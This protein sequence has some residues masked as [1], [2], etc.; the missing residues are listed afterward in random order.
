MNL[1]RVLAAALCWL[2]AAQACA[3]AD[4]RT[5]E[6]RRWSQ[7]DGAPQTAVALAQT[8][9]GLL[10]F[11]T[12]AGMYT[13]DGVRFERTGAVYR[14]QLRSDNIACMQAL[15]GGL[16]VGYVFGGMSLFSKTGVTHYLPGREL[17]GGSITALATDSRGTV[18]A[19]TSTGVMRL[20]EGRWE[21]VGAGSAPAESPMYVSVDSDDTVW[22]V[23]NYSYQSDYSYYAMPRGS[24]HF[25]RVFGAPMAGTTKIGGR[26]VVMLPGDRYVELAAGAP[27][28]RLALHKPRLYDDLLLGGPA[29]TLWT[30]REDGFVRLARRADGVLEPAETFD[31]PAGMAR[32]TT[33]SLLDREGNLWVATLDGVER[34]RRHRLSRLSGSGSGVNWLAM[35]GLGDEVWYGP[36][37]GPLMRLAADGSSRPTGL[38]SANA[39]LR[40]APDH[41][42][43]ATSDALWEWHGA[44]RIRYALP[45]ADK[46][47]VEV[48]A[49]AMD[50][51]DRLL[52]S[53]IRK[54]L[55]RFEDGRWTRDDRTRGIPDPTPISMLTTAQGRTWLGFTNGR[56]GEL[57]A[58]GIR[59]WPAPLPT[60]NVLSMLEYRGRLFV[61]G[62][63]GVSWL[64]GDRAR[65]LLLRQAGAMLGVA[66]MAAD[67][68][69]N[70]WLHGLDGLHR[71]AADA[72]AG[73]FV[74][75]GDPVD[76]ELFNFED[77]LRGQVGQM[78]PLPALAA[79]RGRIWF[80]TVAQAGWLDPLAIPRNPRAPDVLIRSLHAG[81]RDYPAVDGVK[82]PERTTSLDVAFTA[83]ALSIPERARLRY[84]LDGVDAGWRDV[85]HE[86]S[87]SYTN[88]AP[89]SYRFHVIAANEDGVWNAAGAVLRFDIA[90][91][92]WQTAWFRVLCVVAGLVVMA[93]LYRWRLAIAARRATERATARM[94]ERERIARSLHDTLLQAVQGMVLRFQAE[95]WRMPPESPSAAALDAALSD[96]DRLIA[97]TRDEVMALRRVP[98]AAELLDELRAAVATLAPGS[99]HLLHF[100]LQ[101]EPRRLRGETAG[102]IFCALR[103]AAVNSVRHARAG[104]IAVELRFLPRV[105]EA[106]VTDDGI[107][108]ERE[109]AQ[110]GRSGHFGIVGMR[111]RIGHLGGRIA[112]T[113]APGGGTVV[114]IRIPARAAY[115]AAPRPRWRGWLPW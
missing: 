90:P 51:Q 100:A 2:A 30:S 35:P 39:V 66:G 56:L 106:S 5:F 27:P 31:R 68:R 7:A 15:P 87:A 71:I 10:W 32:Y 36:A 14:G 84:R 105:L 80:A 16:A 91:A 94:E 115:E 99:D 1:T 45:G 40:A 55:W 85:Q 73:A 26:Q 114:R 112:V 18:F 95:V 88:L 109:V 6:R 23:F 3:A 97:S 38:A 78:R 75:P 110:S 52:A 79:A 81:G 59:L 62:E 21:A 101:G 58:T 43:V 17:P 65:P 22:A 54:G 72:L 46:W 24:R 61:G 76:G 89:G 57:T 98:Q 67:S 111:E 82:L 34:Y 37:N 74:A 19:G 33:A 47:G 96:A 70:L 92:L 60:G 8:D 44:R 77:G 49:L 107:G 41:V 42:W 113:P 93:L 20:R 25:R 53:L 108:I 12:A 29:G 48:Q 11:G 69:G 13:F 102:E 9:D 50:G 83:T 86:R 64:D 4:G 104:R 63:R 28:R 103:E